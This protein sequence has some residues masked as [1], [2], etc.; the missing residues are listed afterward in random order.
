MS[1][2]RVAAFGAALLVP[3]S[4]HAEVIRFEVLQSAPAF[5]GRSFGNVG[6]YVKITARATI[7]VDPADPNNA[8]IADIDQAPRDDRGLV[9]ATADVVLLRPADPLRAN[10][11]LLV[12]IPNRGRKLAPELFDD[13]PPSRDR[14]TP[15]KPATP[16]SAFCTAKATPWP[17]SAG[18]PTSPQSPGNSRSPHPC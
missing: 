16:A 13:T 12:D 4:A 14:T 1:K 5:E 15:R 8:V 17:G 7:A 10:G 2:L 9:E 3:A 18:R 11:T 6:A